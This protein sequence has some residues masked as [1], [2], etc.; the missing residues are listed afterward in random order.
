MCTGKRIR[1]KVETIGLS[2]IPK[3]HKPE[4]HELYCAGI[5]CQ[6]KVLN[7]EVTFSDYCFK[8][9]LWSGEWTKKEKT[10]ARK[11]I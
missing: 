6:R 3:G 2:P 4:R 9:S 8:T 5:Q 11:P 10:W 1:N 7:R